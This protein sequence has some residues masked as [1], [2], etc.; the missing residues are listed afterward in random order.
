M[1][2]ASKEQTKIENE[3]SDAPNTEQ[4]VVQNNS[5]SH[6]KNKVQFF[7]PND[8]FNSNQNSQEEFVLQEIPKPKELI[9]ESQKKKPDLTPIPPI[10]HPEKTKK[11]KNSQKPMIKKLPSEKKE[12][13]QEIAPQ[14]FQGSIMDSSKQE[15]ISISKPLQSIPVSNQVNNLNTQNI[16]PN[17]LQQQK[18]IDLIEDMTEVL[19]VLSN[20]LKVPKSEEEKV[21]NRGAGNI[22]P[23]TKRSSPEIRFVSPISSYIG[24]GAGILR[25]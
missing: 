25:D 1:P 9:S 19:K 21:G 18:Q 7:A 14:P 2:S 4:N 3:I 10:E 12:I 15:K 23:V 6:N 17:T 24:S 11:L 5:I 16:I 20:K 22:L 13:L 8:P